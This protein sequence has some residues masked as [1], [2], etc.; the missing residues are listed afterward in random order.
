[1]VCEQV[2]VHMDL[3]EAFEE[4]DVILLL[5]DIWL[6]EGPPDEEKIRDQYSEYGQLMEVRANREVKVIVSGGSFVNLR[7]SLLIN[8]ARSIDARRFVAVAT[9]LE[10]EAR[11]IL[12]KRLNV[13]SSGE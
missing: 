11:A 2:S 4:A 8:N 1:M 12:A 13:R 3:E 5:E 6:D 9:Q 7:C 10:N